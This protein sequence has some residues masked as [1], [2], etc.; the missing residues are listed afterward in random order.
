MKGIDNIRTISLLGSFNIGDE[1]FKAIATKHFLQKIKIESNIK[2]SD[3]SLKAI[4]KNC[5]ELHH[6]YMT[7]CQK[8]T[9]SSLRNLAHCKHLTVVNIADCI[10]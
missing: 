4:G 1:S 7:D 2:I 5:P 9:D 3:A 8:L 10:R 6:L